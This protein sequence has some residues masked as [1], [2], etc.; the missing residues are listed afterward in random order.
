MYM[1]NTRKCRVFTGGLDHPGPRVSL[2][3][4]KEPRLLSFLSR[5]TAWHSTDCLNNRQRLR[6]IGALRSAN[7]A[8]SP[9]VSGRGSK[10]R[11]ASPQTLRSRRFLPLSTLRGSGGTSGAVHCLRVGNS[12]ALDVVCPTI[13]ATVV[14]ALRHGRCQRTCTNE[15]AGPVHVRHGERVAI[16]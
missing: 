11:R 10:M 4:Y 15:A 2:S 14:V 3:Q 8:F 13:E 5:E 16:T 1:N 9:T 7:G 12:L 6:E